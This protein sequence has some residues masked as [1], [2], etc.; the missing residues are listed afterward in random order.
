[1]PTVSKQLVEALYEGVSTPPPFR[2]N[3]AKG[4]LLHGDFMASAQAASLSTASHFAGGAVPVLARFSNFSGVPDIADNAPQANPRGL[5]LRFVLPDGAATDIVAHAANGFPASTPGEFLEFLRAAN[6]GATNPGQFDEYLATHAAA[7]RF[8]ELPLHTPRSYLSERYYA[9]HAFVFV[10]RDGR[11]IAGRYIVEPDAG[12][13][14]W[15]P[16][17]AVALPADFLQ[18]EIRERVARGAARMKL[19]LQLAEPGDR[20]DDIAA[21]WPLDRAR[22]TLG[23]IVLTRVERDEAAQAKLMFDP[24]RLAD[25]IESAGDPILAARHDSYAVSFGRRWRAVR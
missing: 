18:F 7:K 10:A 8:V 20:L 3:H 12:I 23:E 25:G 13:Q 15:M 5:A 19:T 22:V 9:M 16:Q 17:E 1:M 14:H 4:T 24:A 6:R 11:R 21:P 2:V